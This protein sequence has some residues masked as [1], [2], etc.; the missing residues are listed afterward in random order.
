MCVIIEGNGMVWHGM[1]WCGMGG[2][3]NGGL[4]LYV[5]GWDRGIGV[6]GIRD[7]VVEAGE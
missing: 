2:F 4:V 1:V 3:E 5:V 7:G 6:R